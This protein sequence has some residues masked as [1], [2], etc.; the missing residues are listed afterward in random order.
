MV[1]K[2]LADALK[3]Y[4]LEL[5]KQEII[6]KSGNNMPKESELNSKSFLPNHRNAKD[7]DL[8]QWDPN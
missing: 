6:E 2:K 5:Q 7:Y 3:K 1:D 8:N 4:D